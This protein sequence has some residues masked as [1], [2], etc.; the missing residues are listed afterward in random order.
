MTLRDH[1]WKRRYK[2][3]SNKQHLLKELFR[4]ALNESLLYLRGSGSFSS[5]LFNTIGEPLADFIE[6]GGVMKL[7]T[8]VEFSEQDKEAIDNGIK[9]W[10]T[11]AEEK[12]TE[13]IDNEFR[14]PMK[15]GALLLTRL[16]EMG[17][18]EIKI[19]YKNPGIYHEKIGI[20]FD[21]A[22]IDLNSS[23]EKIRQYD[24]LTFFAS[25]ND[26]KTGW[27]FSHE[28]VKVYPSWIDSRR[29][30]ALDTL[31][32]FIENWQ[33]QTEGLKVFDLKEAFKRKLIKIKMETENLG[34]R[35][36]NDEINASD[37]KWIHQDEAVNWFVDSE[38][39]NGIGIFEM[40][41]G[42][43]KTRTAMRCMRRLLN[44]KIVEK[45]IIAVPNSLLTQWKKEMAEFLGFSSKG[46]IIK[47]LSE[48]SGDKKEHFDFKNS[49][50]NA[51]LIVSHSMLTKFLKIARNWKIKHTM[52]IVD[53]MHNIGANRFLKLEEMVEHSDP[54]ALT[55]E[56]IIKAKS[57]IEKEQNE[58]EAEEEIFSKFEYRLGLSATPWCHYDN[59]NR[60]NSFL[61]RNFTRWKEINEKFF[62]NDWQKTLRENNMVFYFG[63]KEGIEKD[64]LCEFNYYPLTFEPSDKEKEKYSELIRKSFGYKDEEGEP[65]PLGAI[66]AAAV[67]KRSREKIP[68]F[69]DWLRINPRLDRTLIFV[70]DSYFGNDIMRILNELGYSDFTKYF[71][72][73]EEWNL[74]SFASGE[75]N[76]LISCHRISEGI[77][78][79]SVKQIILFSSAS[80]PLEII[81]RIG[82]ALRKGKEGKTASIVDFI[83]DNPSSS[84]NPDVKRRD[85][86][87]ELSKARNPI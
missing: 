74:N 77:D 39:A 79:K 42:S 28:N 49:K 43:G 68:V 29:D 2:S 36:Q 53:E 78:I 59:D 69:I 12:I 1:I 15:K 21:K 32:D 34:T 7:I 35:T 19:G 11:I 25:I 56:E 17:R 27:K 81:Q 48:Y 23:I 9:N 52:I 4:P 85:W 76:F 61:I 38:E 60:R 86:L 30:D 46:G 40:A 22:S 71:Q 72:G 3:Q 44:S 62:N 87:K 55:N 63:L 14:P 67:F 41:T 10:K 5:S 31:D 58:I 70:E 73:D 33:G 83:Y 47:T 64:I 45:I 37:N 75:T 57:E 18:L 20:F 16:L 84:S 24:F 50:K 8:N 66:R 65:S 82:R 51:F 6:R 54:I 13:I 26:S 80:S